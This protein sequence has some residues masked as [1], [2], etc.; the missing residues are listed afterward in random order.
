DGIMRFLVFPFKAYVG[1][2]GGLPF[3]TVGVASSVAAIV[4]FTLL[5]IFASRF[6]FVNRKTKAK[7]VLL[8]GAASIVICL[9]FALA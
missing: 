9:L 1:F 8:G 5:M 2:V 3:A 4:C 7:G 6:V